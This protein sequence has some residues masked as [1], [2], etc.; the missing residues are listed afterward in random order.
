MTVMM[1]T[2]FW[3]EPIAA[4]AAVVQEVDVDC[5]EGRF[6]LCIFYDSSSNLIS[7][8]CGNITI[9]KIISQH[10]RSSIECYTSILLSVVVMMMR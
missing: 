8:Y 4:G 10:A 3:K 9:F 5:M 1:M 6:E 2:L 7:Y